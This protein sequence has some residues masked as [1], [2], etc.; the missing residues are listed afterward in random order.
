L[1][2]KLAFGGSK[3]GDWAWKADNAF[4]KSV[5]DYSYKPI[6]LASVLGSYAWDVFFL[7]FWT[8]LVTALL[9]FGTKKMQIL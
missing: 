4:F 1:N 2:D 9:V 6:A 3:T 8:F 7:A 5:P